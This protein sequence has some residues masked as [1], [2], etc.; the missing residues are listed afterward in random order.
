MRD[1]SPRLENISGPGQK[2]E[3]NERERICRPCTSY[4]RV[5]SWRHSRRDIERKRSGQPGMRPNPIDSRSPRGPPRKSGRRGGDFQAC[6]SYR[7]RAVANPF[8]FPLAWQNSFF[9][10]SSVCMS[11]SPPPIKKGG[12]LSLFSFLSKATPV[13]DAS[14]K[15]GAEPRGKKS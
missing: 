10:D 2:G 4:N 14:I 12:H 15:I 6:H 8:F 5:T 9:S 11:L 7:Q 1:I 13:D 3:E